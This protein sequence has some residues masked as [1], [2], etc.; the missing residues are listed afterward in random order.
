[1]LFIIYL[2]DLPYGL[3]Q[4]T[5]PVIYV[6]DVSVI[7]TASNEAALKTQMSQTDYMIK[8]FTAN[9]L[10]L[11]TDKTNIIKFSP[12]NRRYNVQLICHS[13]LL[14]AVDST[15]FLRLELDNHVNWKSHIKKILPKLS[16]ACYVI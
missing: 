13:K 11:N 10:S 16:G 7:L 15:K 6:D 2:N 12:S 14:S 9:G 1:L 8:W 4:E 3:Q 5:K